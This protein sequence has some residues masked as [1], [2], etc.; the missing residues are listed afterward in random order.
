MTTN[1]NILIL[2]HGGMTGSSIS[3][4][5]K[6]A[7]VKSLY[8][9]PRSELDLM[10]QGAVFHYLKD[11]DIDQV[12]LCAAKVGGIHA[13]ARYP[14]DFIYQNL[15]IQNNVIDACY[16][17]KVGR[18]M[19]LGSSC[20]YPRHAIQPIPENQLL[21]G[22]LEPTNEAYAIA[23]ISGIKMCESYN[24]QYGTDFRCIMPTNL[25]GPGD[26]FHAE[27]SHVIAGLMRRFHEAKIARAKSVTVWGSGEPR[28]EFLYIEDFSK[29]AVH[30]MTMEKNSFLSLGNDSSGHINI[31]NGADV[32]IRDLA[33]EI[34]E[35]VGFEGGIEFDTSKPDGTP[36]KLLDVS[37]AKRG[38]WSSET[39]LRDGLRQTYS[40]YLAPNGQ[41]RL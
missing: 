20:I 35:V 19:F 25:Y 7:G 31:G 29:A 5:L 15:Q 22:A 37:R 6:R 30:F 34:A 21:T 11:L 18:L 13:N 23:K 14:A 1:K 32:T 10:E 3:M 28:R 12:Y 8:C 16:R 2:G 41:L 36:R 26:N 9:P 33:Y 4:T 39:S 38:G 17:S 24:R 27:D 40:W